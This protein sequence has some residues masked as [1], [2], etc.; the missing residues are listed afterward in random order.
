[1]QNVLK[2]LMSGLK[3][4]IDKRFRANRSD[5]SQNDSTAPD[6]IKNRPFWSNDTEIHQLDEKYIPDSIARVGYVDDTVKE[7]L[8]KDQSADLIIEPV[9]TPIDFTSSTF[10]TIGAWKIVCGSFKQVREKVLNGEHPIILLRGEIQDTHAAYNQT[11]RSYMVIGS[12]RAYASSTSDMV[13][14]FFDLY[15]MPNTVKTGS[16]YLICIRGKNSQ[17]VNIDFN[18]MMAALE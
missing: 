10:K 12:E 1:M 7:A 4:F 2:T 9:S 17:I 5:W 18:R 16:R 11:Y 8:N 15:T 14:V 3:I 13:F 6:Y